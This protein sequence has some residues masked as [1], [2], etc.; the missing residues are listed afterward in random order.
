MPAGVKLP[1][2]L[3]DDFG[4]RSPA[5]HCRVCAVGGGFS[6]FLVPF[7]L[8]LLSPCEQTLYFPTPIRR[9]RSELPDL[10]RSK[11]WN[12]LARVALH[13]RV[14]EGGGRKVDILPTLMTLGAGANRPHLSV[15]STLVTLGTFFIGG[16]VF[17]D[18]RSMQC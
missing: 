15:C 4:S 12:Y 5:A 17:P 8:S 14:E 7:K 9:N 13:T 10:P 6:T 2:Q 18:F 16:L 11:L 3:L 1:V